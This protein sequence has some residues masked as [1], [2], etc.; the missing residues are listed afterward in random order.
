MNTFTID[1][2]DNSTRIFTWS[3]PA[4]TREFT[5]A[6]LQAFT[7]WR[8][9]GG[10]AAFPLK[11][12]TFTIAYPETEKVQDELSAAKDE[13]VALKAKLAELEAPII[14][15]DKAK[16]DIENDLMSLFS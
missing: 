12:Q 13:I 5:L 8:A 7:H 10:V 14:A 4:G 11:G 1:N 9:A 3:Y 2:I 6:D 16:A 15:A